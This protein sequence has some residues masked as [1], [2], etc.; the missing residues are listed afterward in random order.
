M[1]MKIE[2]DLESRLKEAV[3][4][5]VRTGSFHKM[6]LIGCAKHVCVY[7]LGRYFKDAFNKQ[8][9]R[10]RFHVDM[11]CDSDFEKVKSLTNRPE[12]EGLR[13]I[14]VDELKNTE[15]VYVIVM[16]GNPTEVL[17]QIGGAIGME[18][19][20]AYNDVALDDVISKEEKYRKTEYFKGEQENIIKAFHLLGDEKSRER[21]V[22]VICNRIAPQMSTMSYDQM[23]QSLQYFPNDV[24]KLTEHESVVDGGAYTGD[25]LSSF[26]QVSQNQFDAYHAFEI[27]SKNFDRLS[28]E[29]GKH[30]PSVQNKIYCYQKGLWDVEGAL[31][32]GRQASDDSYSM[33]NGE[34]TVAVET[35]SLDGFLGEERIT[36]I[37]MDIEGAEW[38]A[39]QGAKGIIE[40]Q[41]PKMAI[42]VYHR[43]EDIWKIP[44]FLKEL[45]PE[46]RIAI[47][48]HAKFWVAE[49][50]CYAYCG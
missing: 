1:G 34:D 44:I 38:K 35:V 43:L 12:Y 37:K 3:A 6:N 30:K 19:C 32:Y 2:M 36:F 50:V 26:L 46:Y 39:L 49:T 40:N 13:G 31:S 48:H 45:V 14:S 47:R 25:T 5:A 21:Y 15:N 41:K 29:R 27:D 23:Y 42:C 10:K 17:R 11:L 33:Y 22:N 24:F 4:Y 9:V 18:N 20:A 28:Q 8:K 7:G 16:L